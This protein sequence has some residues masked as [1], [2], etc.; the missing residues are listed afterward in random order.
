MLPIID[1]VHTAINAGKDLSSLNI[2]NK[3]LSSLNKVVTAGLPKLTLSQN[4]WEQGN[5]FIVRFNPTYPKTEHMK[6]KELI[7]KVLGGDVYHAAKV[8]GYIKDKLKEGKLEEFSD[9]EF[10]R[11]KTRCDKIRSHQVL[12]GVF[13]QIMLHE[14][15]VPLLK[16]EQLETLL[17]SLPDLKK[18]IEL[19]QN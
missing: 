18:T 6:N 17:S 11:L 14:Q 12:L 7:A 9:S 1:I 13:T 19:F 8:Q 16:N 2:G 4:L 3:G 15:M 5:Q 10:A